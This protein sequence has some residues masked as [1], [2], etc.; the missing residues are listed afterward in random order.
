MSKL[1][2]AGFAR[3]LRN[4]VLLICFAILGFT[5]GI[6]IIISHFQNEEQDAPDTFLL[7]GL[8]IVSIMTAVFVTSF[9]GA[10]HRFGTIRNKLIVGQ[11]R[12]SVYGSS[13]LVCLTGMLMMFALVWILTLV[14]GNL[15][16]GGFEKSSQ[17]LLILFLRSL[18]AMTA[19]TALYTLIGLCI[20]SKSKGSV[21]AVICAFVMLIGSVAVMQTLMEPEYYPQDATIMVDDMEY[22]RVGEEPVKNP[23]YVTGNKRRFYQALYDLSPITQ[24]LD[25]CDDQETAP[26]QTAKLVLIPCAEMLLLFCAGLCIFKKRDL[27]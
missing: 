9:L 13:F 11:S 12:L 16:L 26:G 27:K 21:A 22:A 25:E 7:S 6:S 5:N 23:Y 2:N 20:H 8:I 10:E 18:L 14:L 1:L 15:V 4:K 17:E 3:M 19:L 24:I